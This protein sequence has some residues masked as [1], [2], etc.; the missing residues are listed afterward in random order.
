M[1]KFVSQRLFHLSSLLLVACNTQTIA[2]PPGIGK[3]S[4]INNTEVDFIKELSSNPVSS[5]LHFA[6]GK[7]YY[8]TD[9]YSNFELARSA[10]QTALKYAPD[11]PKNFLGIAATSYKLGSYLEAVL[12]YM[13]A[14][15]RQEY[16]DINFVHFAA[17][18]YRAGLFD[19]S[20]TAFKRIEEAKVSKTDE[21]LYRYLQLA[22]SEK[23][24]DT[25]IF[26]AR[27]IINKDVESASDAA[28]RDIADTIVA[29]AFLVQ[30]FVSNRERVGSN[31]LENLGIG[32]AGELAWNSSTNLVDDT[33]T[34]TLDRALIA[35]LPSNLNY[36]LELLSDEVTRTRIEANPN[37]T[38]SKDVPASISRN[39]NYN[40]FSEDSEGTVYFSGDAGLSTGVSVQLEL[41][42]ANSTNAELQISIKTGTLSDSA[43]GNSGLLNVNYVK[44]EDFSIETR[45][46]VP[47]GRV[48]TLGGISLQSL[49]DRENGLSDIRNFPI[50]G[51]IFGQKSHEYRRDDAAILL[52]V[53]K[54]PLATSID[55]FDRIYEVFDKLDISLES[56]PEKVGKNPSEMPS[57]RTDF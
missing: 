21:D 52:T 13:N 35:A 23:I 53:R 45:T 28:G 6:V 49:A 27:S 32:L 41:I 37:I 50:V 22:F 31:F 30:H 47:Y 44:S 38:L 11:N 18:T 39:E 12:A 29:D 51:S 1:I 15:L 9:Q 7:Y 56:F 43:D 10:F 26:A 8:E 57:I 24:Y 40:F 2:V 19:L 36:S 42:S 54:S 17:V 34:K 3:N 25:D 55:L 14:I 33:Y 5:E 4:N 16:K 20:Y 46:N 48:V